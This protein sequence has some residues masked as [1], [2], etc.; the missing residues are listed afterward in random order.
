MAEPVPNRANYPNRKAKI[1]ISES[2][3]YTKIAK[4][5]MKSSGF[6]PSDMHDEFGEEYTCPNCSKKTFTHLEGSTSC[7]CCDKC[8]NTHSAEEKESGCGREWR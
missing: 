2:K 4:D 5:Y 6:T 7:P 3:N 1:S 8:W